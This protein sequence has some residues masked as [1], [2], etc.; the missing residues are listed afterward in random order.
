[1]SEERIK[2]TRAKGSPSREFTPL[3]FFWRL[4]FALVMV[5][6]TYN[7]SGTSF[8]HWV[9]AA[10]SGDGVGPLHVFVGLLLLAGWTILWVATW[11]SLDTFGVFLAA[12]VIAALVWLLID[13]GLLEPDT[14]TAIGWI[15]LVSLS[16]LLS[17]GLSWSHIWRRLT[18][19]FE[20]DDDN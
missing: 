6:A 12:A 5:L 9:S 11:R 19:Q 17:I 8:Y 18:G 20:V 1:M 2:T 10:F 16:L 4:L 14:S 15:V 3:S 13:L 7:P